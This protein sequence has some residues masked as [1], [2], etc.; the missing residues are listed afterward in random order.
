MVQR[1]DLDVVLDEVQRVSLALRVF[2]ELLSVELN[3]RVSWFEIHVSIEREVI[4][5]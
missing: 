5:N 2:D 3:L 4:R 1:D